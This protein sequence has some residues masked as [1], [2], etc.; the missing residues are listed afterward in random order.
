MAFG[1]PKK[2]ER[3]GTELVPVARTS[4]SQS[5][6][7][8]SRPALTP[9]KVACN[10]KFAHPNLELINFHRLSIRLRRSRSVLWA[11]TPERVGA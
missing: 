6:I 9:A 5:V 3:L 8:R 10:T 11:F 4:V 2:D 7:S 1:R